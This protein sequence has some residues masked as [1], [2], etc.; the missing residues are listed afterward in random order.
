MP[1]KLPTKLDAVIAILAI[2]TAAMAIEDRNRA[3]ISPPP[4]TEIAFLETSSATLSRDCAA[5][6]AADESEA[7]RRMTMM[8]LGIAVPE[9]RH[10]R[11]AG[12]EVR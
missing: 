4:P 3:E 11:S 5:A 9:R 2:A 12:C 8:A 1:T 10:L 7:T 6:I